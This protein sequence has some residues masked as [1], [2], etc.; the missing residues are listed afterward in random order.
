MI[1]NIEFEYLLDKKKKLD[2]FEGQDVL[3]IPI[4]LISNK[5]KNI[6]I[7]KHLPTCIKA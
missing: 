6:S 5:V 2:Y 7:S 4:L 1:C 3:K